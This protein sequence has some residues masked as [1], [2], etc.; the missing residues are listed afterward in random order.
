MADYAKRVGVDLWGYKT[1]DGRSLR[2]A[3][4]YLIP[5]ADGSKPWP[6]ENDPTHKVDG[7]KLVLPLLRASQA[8]GEPSYTERAKTLGKANWDT[9]R[10]RLLIAPQ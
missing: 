3:L 1:T 2:G 9:L 4:E 10:D 5:F 6:H 7:S 8:F